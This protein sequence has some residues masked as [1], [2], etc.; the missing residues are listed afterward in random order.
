MRFNENRKFHELEA[1]DLQK[2]V[3]ALEIHQ[4]LKGLKW[5]NPFLMEKRHKKLN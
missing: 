4:S 2:T 3:N 5:I 1:S